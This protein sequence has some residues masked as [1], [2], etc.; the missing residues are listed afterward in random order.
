MEGLECQGEGRADALQRAGAPSIT[1]QTSGLVPVSGFTSE[2]ASHSE[3]PRDGLA[4]LARS[5]KY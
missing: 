3:S 4:L 5:S 2:S 1:L